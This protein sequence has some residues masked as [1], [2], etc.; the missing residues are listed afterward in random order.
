[1]G[2]IISFSF[3]TNPRGQLPLFLLFPNEDQGIEMSSKLPLKSHTANKWLA[4]GSKMTLAK[5]KVLALPAWVKSCNFLS[6]HYVPISP[7]L[8]TVVI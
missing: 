5:A 7:Q 4:L 3:L 6:Q 8:I 1:M 2:H